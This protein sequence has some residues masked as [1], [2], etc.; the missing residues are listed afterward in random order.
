MNKTQK[1][2]FSVF[3]V[4]LFFFVVNTASA[5][6]CQGKWTAN[7]GIA[8]TINNGQSAEFEYTVQ[9]VTTRNGRYSINLYRDNTIIHTYINNQPTVNNGAGGYITVMPSHYGNIAGNYKVVI[10]ATDDFGS[11]SFTITLKI[12]PT[13]GPLTLI[14]N[15]NPVSGNAPLNVLFTA[16]AS[17][18]SGT[19]T[20]YAWNFG[21]GTNGNGNPI[22][23]TYSAGTYIP[24]VTVTD[25]AGNTASA[26]CPTITV[27]ASG[28][29]HNLAV[30][31]TFPTSPQNEGTYSWFASVQN[32]GDFT[33][34]SVLRFYIN[35]VEQTDCAVLI[36]NLAAGATSNMY[37]CT[38]YFTAGIYTLSVHVDQV[39][40]ETDL[41]DNTANYNF[42]VNQITNPLTVVCN[43][44][45]V[46]GN[47]PLNVLFTAT[48]SGGSGTYTNYAWN[49]GDGSNQNTNVNSVTHTYNAGIYNP[50]ITVTDSLGNTASANCPTINVTPVV[51]PLAVTINATPISGLAP[52]TVQ[53]N[54][55]VTGGIQP[56][57]YNWNFADG[58]TSA[59][60]NPIHTFDLPGTYNV[61][62]TV[63]DSAGN[64]AS[65]NIIITVTGALNVSELECFPNVIVGNLQACTL[66]VTLQGTSIPVAD[67]NVRLYDL[68]NDT[69][70]GNCI[71]DVISGS[72]VVIYPVNNLGTF[73]VYATAERPGYIS[74]L[75][76][77]PTFTYNV[78]PNIYTISNLKI[79]NDT[80]ITEDYDFFRNET[81]YVRFQVLD[82]NNNSVNDLV[83]SVTLVSQPGGREQLSVYP[84]QEPNWYRYYGIIPRTHDFLGDSQV[85]VISLNTNNNSGVQQV[86]SLIIR[87]NPPRI[88]G[89]PNT[90][91]LNNTIQIDLSQY[92]FDVE[93]TAENLT[94]SFSGVDPNIITATIN[95][96][97][98]T[99]V[100]IS[101]GDDRLTLTLRDL[102]GATA[103]QDF[104]VSVRNITQNNTIPV[105]TVDLTPDI[106]Y[107]NDDLYCYGRV[108]DPDNDLI[109][110]NYQIIVSDN[111]GERIYSSGN[112]SCNISNAANYYDCSATFVPNTAT[113]PGETWT[114]IMQPFDGH[115]QGAQ[116]SDF[117]II[118]EGNSTR[119]HN[120]A[121]DANFPVNPQSPGNIT[122][123]AN[124]RN[125]G[126]YTENS[127][128]RFFVDGVELTNCGYNLIL[129]PGATTVNLPCTHYFAGGTYNLLVSVDP[130]AN[131]T[132]LFDNNAT[133]TLI[134]S[135]NHT[136]NVRCEVD[137]V[138][139]NVPLKVGFRGYV[140]GTSPQQVTYDYFW[141]FGDEITGRGEIVEHI[142]RTTGIFYPIL[143]VRDSLGNFGTANCHSIT[144]NQ[145]L[146]NT[147]NVLITANPRNG[148][149]PLKVDFT[150][151]V[152]GGSGIYSYRWEFDDGIISTARNPTHTYRN[153]GRYAVRFYVTDSQGRTGFASIL[154]T[155]EDDNN[156]YEL[157]I[158]SIDLYGAHG[159]IKTGD[160]LESIVSLKN[161]GPVL[162]DV[163]IAVTIMDLGL[164]KTI[165]PFDIAS[166]AVVSKNLILE[167][168]EGVS[169]EYDVEIAVSNDFLT[170]RAYRTIVINP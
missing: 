119:I 154:I 145:N 99:L 139:G 69:F 6:L 158:K 148:K 146:N 104:L 121:V 59:L 51:N 93:D 60:P 46:S 159:D 61:V 22:T 140:T 64:T 133:S 116:V 45:P 37:S 110:A 83:N 94:W 17:G 9:A 88:I 85:F 163:K 169:G 105:I 70:Y 71:T 92:E 50:T 111:N 53:F 42:V 29:V 152:T 3:A 114:C 115:I 11:Y 25:S 123:Y 15:A 142:Y 12:N 95:G 67:A 4:F 23:H 65:D 134:V 100:P 57:Y 33:E 54:S 118:G 143:T 16:T 170:K 40:G 48:A 109:T 31:G 166:G 49:F 138:S 112:V 47:A 36:T 147:L 90:I 144:V 97:I 79:Y 35:G 89:L 155:V 132:N 96:K 126:D 26:N 102:D 5:A 77:T 87:N 19:Y 103:S 62:L 21:D 129:T 72:C 30:Y 20:N 44:N 1:T 107:D 108:F 10:Y 135:G 43:A 74:D 127:Q 58:S 41:A 13:T 86:V 164:R 101:V 150:S 151:T 82:S 8:L 27:S 55:T 81:M 68:S 157:A 149:A 153:N 63:T 161:Y 52:L 7:N 136:L 98:L 76:K 56:Y 124:V 128:L 38:R 18:G 167:L 168:P 160:D 32:R 156:N 165:G 75:D 137:P 91:E 130:V 39:V 120:L 113:T 78:L 117:V 84:V 73:T 2:I 24:A 141:D 28:L 66:R 34:N 122:W 131:E 162:K 80:F 125:T 106:P 14:C